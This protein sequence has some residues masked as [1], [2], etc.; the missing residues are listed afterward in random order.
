MHKCDCKECRKC[1]NCKESKI[2]LLSAAEI[3]GYIAIVVGLI[4]AFS[5]MKKSQGSKNVES[6]SLIYLACAMIAEFVFLI[7]GIVLKNVSIVVT[8]IAG[9]IYFGFLLVLFLMYESKKK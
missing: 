7:Q 2:N 5:Q 9:A 4:G 3:L 1:D 6:F 8:K